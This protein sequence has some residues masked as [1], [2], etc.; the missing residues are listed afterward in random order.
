M[1]ALD[2][3]TNTITMRMILAPG[4]EHPDLAEFNQK[5][6]AL[7]RVLMATERRVAKNSPNLVFRVK[8]LRM[9]SP[10]VVEIEATPRLAGLDESHAVMASVIADIES[11]QPQMHLDRELHKHASAIM[12]LGPSGDIAATELTWNGRTAT[13]NSATAKAFEEAQGARYTTQGSR[14]GVLLALNLRPE[15]PRFEI[16]PVV[17]GQVRCR[18]ERSKVEEAIRAV[19]KHVLVT[20]RVHW[21]DH[22]D[23][24]LLIEAES[25]EVLEP[26]G[27]MPD[28][29]GVGGKLI[30]GAD[31][32]GW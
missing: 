15:K 6:Q 27:P 21:R 22:L 25:I 7:A 2:T 1:A 30:R 14:T 10:P 5:V 4:V 3:N 19:G 24:P 31:H 12:R 32:D 23:H 16:Y 18:F 13:I 28:L 8:R 17:G 9:A 29:A 11:I 26:V 20:G